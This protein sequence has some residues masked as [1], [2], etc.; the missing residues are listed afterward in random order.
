MNYLNII[1]KKYINKGFNSKAYIVNDNYILLEGV[2]HNSFNNYLKY[3]KTIS[4]I[5]N[6]KSLEIPKIIELVKP[7]KDYPF[8]ALIYKMIKGHA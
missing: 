8:G 1:S 4:Q 3:E 7:N 6:I 2:N 5:G